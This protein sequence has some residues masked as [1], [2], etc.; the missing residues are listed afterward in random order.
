MLAAARKAPMRVWQLRA[1][2][3]VQPNRR[4]WRCGQ[5]TTDGETNGSSFHGVKHDRI[6]EERAVEAAMV[7]RRRSRYFDPVLGFTHT[8]YGRDWIGVLPASRVAGV[9]GRGGACVS[10]RPR[11][12]G[13]V[14]SRDRA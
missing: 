10:R 7:A 12:D 11:H 14:P 6:L 3:S 2:T 4:G 9:S 1:S 5:K 13:R 8:Y